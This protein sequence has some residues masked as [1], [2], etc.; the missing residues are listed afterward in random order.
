LQ[1]PGRPLAEK[2]LG[3]ANQLTVHVRENAVEIE[4]DA[5]GHRLEPLRGNLHIVTVAWSRV[6]TIEVA[7]DLVQL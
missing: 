4:C 5:E 3:L 2:K 7:G 1:T 6:E